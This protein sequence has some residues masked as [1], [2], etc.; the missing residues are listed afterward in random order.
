MLLAILTLSISLLV[1]FI[2]FTFYWK[3]KAE[4][5]RM[6]KQYTDLGY[7]VY[8]HPFS[9]WSP[10]FLKVEEKG[11]EEYRD[12]KHIEKH[13]LIDKDVVL[14][15]IFNNITILLINPDLQKNLFSPESPNLYHKDS[16]LFRG[17]T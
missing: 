6:T 12:S 10:T 16:F 13:E 2:V 3:P 8:T 15:N 1:L 11:I 9:F 14:S 4:L 17:I 5:N 7:N